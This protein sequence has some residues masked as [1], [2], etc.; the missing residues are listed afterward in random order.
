MCGEFWSWLVYDGSDLPMK[1]PPYILLSFAAICAF[2]GLLIWFVFLRPAATKAAEGVITYKVLKPAGQYVQYPTFTS[3]SFYTPSIIPIA[4]CYV[5]VIQV[6]Q[7][8]AS[9]GYS[10]NTLA[11]GQFNVGQRVNIQFQERDLPGVWHR[12]YVTGMSAK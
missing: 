11:S 6:D 4:E 3:G 2:F 5:F 10:L 7:L 1:L 8:S 9:V 12:I